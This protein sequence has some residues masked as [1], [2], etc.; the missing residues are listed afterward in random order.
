L[1]QWNWHYAKSAAFLV[2]ANLQ[3]PLRLKSGI[4]SRIVSLDIKIAR[5]WDKER[6][7]ESAKTQYLH[8]QNTCERLGK[9]GKNAF[10]D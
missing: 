9:N 4:V 8:S 1:I 7:P 6:K 5:I 3:R 10:L 2:N